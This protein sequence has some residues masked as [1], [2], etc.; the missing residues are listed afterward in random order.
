MNPDPKSINIPKGRHSFQCGGQ[1]FVVD[2]KYEYIKQIGHGAYGVVCSAQNKRTGQKVAIKKVAN[3]FDDLI[4]GKRIV[5]EIKLL[6]FFKHENIISLYDVQKPEAKTGF[7]DIYIVTE[8]METDLHR[9]IYSRQELTDEHIQYF[10]YQILRGLLYMHSA[11]VIHRDLKPG[12]IL[13]N[14]NCDLKI[15]DLGLARGYENEEDFKTEYVVTRWYRAPEVILN[16]SE[17]SKAVDIYSVGCILAELLGRTPL[18]PGENYLD[19]VQRI[20]AVLGSPTADDMKYIGNNNAIKY[21]KSL[22]KRSKQK[23]EALFPKANNKA[24]DLLG[25]MITFNPEQ[26]YTVEQCLQHPYFDELHN[27]DEE[28]LSGKAFDWSWDNFEPTKEILQNMIYQESL[29]FNDEVP[30]RKK[31]SNQFQLKA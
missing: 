7:N 21:I 26:R 25:K 1:T 30:E 9:V 22:P 18:F 20:I 2:Q 16:A 3:A 11:N 24:L 12:N 6:K 15:C 14:K 29:S 13:V 8:F 4:D 28:P 10:V 17:Y 23:W 19:Q 5:R 31:K 27:P